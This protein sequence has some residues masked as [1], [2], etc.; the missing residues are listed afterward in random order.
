MQYLIS[1]TLLIIINT[2]LKF[3]KMSIIP[4]LIFAFVLYAF[5]CLYVIEET[6]FSIL[7]LDKKSQ[8]IIP[9]KIYEI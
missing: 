6:F 1:N 8:K 7:L 4:S 5:G 9:I 2:F 3:R